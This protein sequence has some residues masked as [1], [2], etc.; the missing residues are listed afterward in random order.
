MLTWA[1]FF[2]CKNCS[3][4][5]NFLEK[6]SLDQIEAQN[7][8]LKIQESHTRIGMLA[9]IISLLMVWIAVATLLYGENLLNIK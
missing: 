4:V 3:N 8:S 6:N 9:N 1:S 7:K 2:I 5:I